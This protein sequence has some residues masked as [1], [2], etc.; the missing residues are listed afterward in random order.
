M[1]RAG[2]A[3]KLLTESVKTNDL[4][5]EELARSE[6]GLDGDWLDYFLG[7]VGGY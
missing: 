1:R 2:V 3:G 5:R 6:G 7:T 4:A